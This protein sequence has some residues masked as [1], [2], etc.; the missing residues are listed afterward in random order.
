MLYE[1]ILANYCDDSCKSKLILSYGPIDK[2]TATYIL[3]LTDDEY[4]CEIKRPG[5][6]LSVWSEKEID[7]LEEIKKNLLKP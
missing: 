6:S 2:K 4:I 5:I 3:G 1:V 7:E